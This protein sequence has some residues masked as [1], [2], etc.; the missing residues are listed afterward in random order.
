MDIK[1]RKSS[2]RGYADHGWLKS[3]HSFSFA[4]YFDPAHMGF[5][6]LRVINED[7]IAPRAGFPTHPHRDMEIFTV[8]VNGSLEHRDSMGNGTVLR[9]GQIQVMSAGSGIT[10]SEFNPSED[11]PAHLLQIWITPRQTGLKPSYADSQPAPSKDKQR[12][13]LIIAR[14]G[15]EGAAMIQQDADVYKIT[16]NAGDHS[17]HEVLKGRGVWIQVISGTLHV[18]GLT[19]AAGDACSTEDPGIMELH[20][21]AQSDALLFDL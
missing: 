17:A 7:W 1:V 8:L 3:Y 12:K 18:N 13:T 9:P 14:D 21:T 5:K 15:R 4:D 16:M 20:T 11:E 10:H 6:S 2:A 19:L